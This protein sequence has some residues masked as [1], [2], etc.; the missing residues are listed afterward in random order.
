MIYIIITLK[1]DFMWLRNYILN[2]N[3]VSKLVH[4]ISFKMQNLTGNL[5][6]IDIRLKIGPM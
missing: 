4:K 6:N 1:S 2:S 5:N 3:L